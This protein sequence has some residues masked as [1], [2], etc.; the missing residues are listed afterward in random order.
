MT[1]TDTMWLVLVKTQPLATTSWLPACPLPSH[2]IGV[3]LVLAV[4]VK[5]YLTWQKTQLAIRPNT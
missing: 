3:L 5:N 1:P 4:P 2:S